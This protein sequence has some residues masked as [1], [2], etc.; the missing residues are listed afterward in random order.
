MLPFAFGELYR[1]L[2]LNQ[3]RGIKLDDIILVVGV[4]PESWRLLRQLQGSG[5]HTSLWN[6]DM[7]P[8]DVIPKRSFVEENCKLG[9]VAFDMIPLGLINHAEKQCIEHGNLLTWKIKTVPSKAQ[10]FW[11]QL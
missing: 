4:I 1:P 9:E 11:A 2:W 8:Y 6:S 5:S 3:Q 10:V 7:N